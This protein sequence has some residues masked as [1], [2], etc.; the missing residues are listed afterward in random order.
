MAT[1]LTSFPDL[2][3]LKQQVALGFPARNA[4]QG[5]PTLIL[6]TRNQVSYRPNI[7]GP[8]SLFV[9][10]RGQSLCGTSSSLARVDES[11]FF[12]SNR[13][14]AY[15][16]SLE[17]G[18]ATETFN[19]H[20]GEQWAE[21]VL[22]N[23]TTSPEHLLDAPNRAAEIDASFFSKLYR[24]DENFNL[25]LARLQ[26]ATAQNPGPTLLSTLR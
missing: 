12:L 10:L 26:V 9:N 23:L 19:L 5:W 16:L 17:P 14:E 25:L 15:T 7:K 24:R 2:A 20:F 18:S 1:L 6:H 22:R 21:D 4:G 8:L 13:G 3:W 11:N